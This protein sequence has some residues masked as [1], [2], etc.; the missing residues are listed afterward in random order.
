MTKTNEALLAYLHVALA[1]WSLLSTYLLETY[2][3]MFTSE[4]TG[5]LGFLIPKSYEDWRSP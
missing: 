5:C 4:G 1:L 2:V 3:H